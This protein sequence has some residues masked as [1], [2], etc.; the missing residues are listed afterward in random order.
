MTEVHVLCYA[1]SAQRIYFRIGGTSYS[2]HISYVLF[3][4][5]YCIIDIGSHSKNRIVG[6][7]RTKTRKSNK[8]D[9]W[10][11]NMDRGFAVKVIG[12]Q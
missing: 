9:D 5:E 7:F 1:L 11:I 10:S 2:Q 12:K 8:A 4:K 3:S 6:P